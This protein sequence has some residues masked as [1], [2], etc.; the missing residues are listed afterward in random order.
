VYTYL[1][2]GNAVKRF[3]SGAVRR[4]WDHAKHRWKLSKQR[5]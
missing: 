4:M 5:H 1:A 3:A 2:A